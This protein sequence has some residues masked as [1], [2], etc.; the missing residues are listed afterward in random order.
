ME[1]LAENRFVITKE[2]YYE[3]ALRVDR[4]RMG[5]FIKKVM[6]ALAAA[7]AVL[8]AFTLFSRGSLVFIL[9]ELVVIALVGVWLTVFFPRNRARRG[10]RA[11]EDRC[12]TDLERV[13]RFYEDRLEIDG[14]GAEVT[15]PYEEAEEFLTSEHLLIL[16]STGKK[17]VLL[18]QDGFTAG[19]AGLVQELIE[20]YRAAPDD[21]DED[22]DE[23]E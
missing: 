4:E 6:L 5:P 9:I 19:S 7:W 2:L 22:E 12:G 18:A 16:L 23:D 14:A 1:P 8:A 13:T 15:I 21:A 10:W 11:L 3:G 20:Q 17:G